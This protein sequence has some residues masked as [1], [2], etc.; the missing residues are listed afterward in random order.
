MNERFEP[1]S[2]AGRAA[3][4]VG[5]SSYS[6]AS[7]LAGYRTDVEQRSTI[8]NGGGTPPSA[9]AMSGPL[10]WWW[11]TNRVGGTYY[12]GR[13]HVVHP[14]QR[15]SGLCGL[16]VDDVW[17]AR[18]PVP[19]HLCPDCCLLAMAVSYPPFPT[20]V[21]RQPIEQTTVLPAVQ[22]RDPRTRAVG[23]RIVDERVTR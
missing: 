14:E 5:P 21:P 17:E 16:P 20:T 12:A 8:M 9:S 13:A 11:G 10:D 23:A 19:E 7:D 6:V 3:G 22:V 1:K 18:P 4:S 15:M 2:T